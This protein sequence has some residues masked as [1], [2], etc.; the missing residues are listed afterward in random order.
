MGSFVIFG[1]GA[2][3][4]AFAAYLKVPKRAYLIDFQVLERHVDLV[5]WRDP[6]YEQLNRHMGES[7]LNP[8]KFSRPNF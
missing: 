8:K 5:Q 7:A 2:S 1:M 4:F 3:V 6:R